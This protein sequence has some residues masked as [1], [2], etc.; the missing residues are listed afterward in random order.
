MLSPSD[1]KSAVVDHETLEVGE[2]VEGCRRS[3]VDEGYEAD[4][5]VGDVA[6]VVEE[7]A[8]DDVAD[9]F[10]GGFGVDVAYNTQ[11]SDFVV[12]WVRKSI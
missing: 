10:D 3:G 8:A 4:V 6:D 11:V 9:F 2:G 5:L 1:F 7:A 12:K